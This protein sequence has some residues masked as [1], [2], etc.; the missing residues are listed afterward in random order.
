MPYCPVFFSKMDVLLLLSLQFSKTSGEIFDSV[1]ECTTS[2]SGNYSGC[3]PEIISEHKTA[4]IANI[5]AII[6]VGTSTNILT[7]LAIPYAQFK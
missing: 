5:A 6:L 3:Q 2:G 7:L 1:I 4:F